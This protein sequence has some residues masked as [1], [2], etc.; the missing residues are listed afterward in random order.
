MKN[1]VTS[2]VS[3]SFSSAKSGG[4]LFQI[5]LYGNPQVSSYPRMEKKWRN[6]WKSWA[7]SLVS[8]EIWGPS[9]WQRGG[10]GGAV[11]TQ[12]QCR[13]RKRAERSA[14]PGE[15]RQNVRYGV[16][17]ASHGYRSEN[18]AA[19]HRGNLTLQQ[20]WVIISCSPQ[21]SHSNWPFLAVEGAWGA[22]GGWTGLLNWY[23]VH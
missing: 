7:S 3:T 10:G 9:V 21:T 22:S 5:P 11:G 20:A 15:K 17:G 2:S 19:G 1:K 16:F 13:R 4:D 18:G 12:K 23:S 8:W 6:C 14:G